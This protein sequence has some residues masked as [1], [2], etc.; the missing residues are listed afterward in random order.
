[1]VIYCYGEHHK[2]LLFL[3]IEFDNRKLMQFA[4]LLFKQVEDTEDGAVYQLARSGNQYRNPDDKVAYPFTEYTGL[5]STFLRNN[6]IPL[7]DLKHFIEDDRL[8]NVPLNQLEVISHGLKN[9]RMVLFENGINLLT[10]TDPADP[11]RVHP[12]DGYCTFK[13]AQRILKRRS[14]LKETDIANESGYYVHNAHNAYNDVWGEV[15]IFTY[16]K[17]IELQQLQMATM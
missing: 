15:S 7:Q 2:Y 6:G 5:T 16:L 12:I 17:K 9:D 1:M 14:N 3:D 4:G 11:K 8:A 13:N 10:Y